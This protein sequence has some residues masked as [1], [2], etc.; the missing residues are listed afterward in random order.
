[1]AAA[2]HCELVMEDQQLGLARGRHRDGRRP[3]HRAEREVAE[4]Q[5]RPRILPTRVETCSRAEY[6]Y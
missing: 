5:K 3:K 1:L 6:E 2:K 4:A